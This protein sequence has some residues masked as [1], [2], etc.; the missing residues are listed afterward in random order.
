MLEEVA[1]EGSDVLW[2]E[3]PYELAAMLS[4]AIP[5]IPAD[6]T[7]TERVSSLSLEVLVDAVVSFHILVF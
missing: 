4:F 5:E 1:D 2:R 6:I 7:E 3:L